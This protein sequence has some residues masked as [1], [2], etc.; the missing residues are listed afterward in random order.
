MQVTRI[1]STVPLRISSPKMP[2]VKPIITTA[3]AT[4]VWALES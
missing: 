1:I 4:A 2:V 3:S